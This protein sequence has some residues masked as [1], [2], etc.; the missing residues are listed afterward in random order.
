MLLVLQTE[1]VMFEI[2]SPYNWNSMF[3]YPISQHFFRAEQLVMSRYLKLKIID[4]LYFKLKQKTKSL[5]H[6]KATEAIIIIITTMYVIFSCPTS[7]FLFN[8]V[9]LSQ[10][11]NFKIL[12]YK[13]FWKIKKTSIK[14]YKYF[15]KQ[16]RQWSTHI[17]FHVFRQW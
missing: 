7:I 13:K 9:T 4:S 8:L 3:Y 15:L 2:E 12:F 1:N 14:F 10:F 16:S 5:R 6:L 11:L 17:T